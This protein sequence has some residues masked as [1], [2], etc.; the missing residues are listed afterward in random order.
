[1]DQ[2]DYFSHIPGKIT[3][4]PYEIIFPKGKG[5]AVH[6]L[7]FRQFCKFSL[8]LN[9][10][11]FLLNGIVISDVYRLFLKSPI[12]EVTIKYV[13]NLREMTGV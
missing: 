13:C 12:G 11:S 9:F 6:R 3:W 1:M 7:L 5:A 2:S 8:K 4:S 10:C